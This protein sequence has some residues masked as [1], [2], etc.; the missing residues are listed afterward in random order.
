MWSIHVGKPR[1]FYEYDPSTKEYWH[2]LEKHK[3]AQKDI[4][5]KEVT[6]YREPREYELRF[7]SRIANHEPAKED[8]YHGLEKKCELQFDDRLPLKGPV[9]G[10]S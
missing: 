3:E 8:F 1:L 10:D 4:P 2:E 6:F 9:I 7:I 5:R